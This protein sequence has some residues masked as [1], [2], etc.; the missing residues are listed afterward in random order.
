MPITDDDAESLAGRILAA[1]DTASPIAPI[2]DERPEFE[3]AD[4]YAVSSR[5]TRR[6]V[7]RGERPVGWKIGFTNR[8]IWDE[9]GVHAPIWGPMYATTLSEV[10]PA[11]GEI[12]CSLQGLSE[13]RLEPEIALRLASPP[14]PGM[15]ERGLLACIDAV[16]HGFEIVQSIFPGWRFRAADTV[17][18]FAL[19][20]RYFRGPL[21]PLSPTDREHWLAALQRFEI[22]LFANGAPV[23]RGAAAN[24]LGGPLSALGHLVR[25]LAE[26]PT[27]RGIEAGDLVTTGTVTRAFP[28][29]PGERWHTEILG[30]PTPGLAIRFA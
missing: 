29:A 19:H 21:V 26:F 7:R 15:D 27:D 12:S 13:P 10:D 24:V 30:L 25:G 17:A 5:V 18:A 4:A 23:D 14:Q 22:A 3:L 1:G 6:R 20:G 16:A 8:T 28:V 2:T 9:Y 11:Q